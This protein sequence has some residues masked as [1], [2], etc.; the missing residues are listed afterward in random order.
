MILIQIKY[1]SSSVNFD[2][3]KLEL[4]EIQNG[5]DSGFVIITII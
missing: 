5:V 2:R 3:D 4:F 1:L